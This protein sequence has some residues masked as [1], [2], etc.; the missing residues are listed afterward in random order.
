MDTWS[1][2]QTGASLDPKAVIEY[3]GKILRF[4]A[5]QREANDG[6]TFSRIRGTVLGDSGNL[7]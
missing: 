6:N 4:D 1:T 5:G 3:S 2:V 7:R